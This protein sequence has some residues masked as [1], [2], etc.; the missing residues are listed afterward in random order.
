[1]PGTGASG[2]EAGPVPL[3][4]PGSCLHSTPASEMDVSLLE[5]WKARS[6]QEAVSEWC[7]VSACGIRL[8]KASS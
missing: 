3:R 4:S 2:L 6:L 7:G 8:E 1:M 5:W